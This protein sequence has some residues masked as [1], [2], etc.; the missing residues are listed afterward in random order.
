MQECLFQYVTTNYKKGVDL[1]PLIR[2]LE[3]V[4]LSSKE[5]T[6]PTGTIYRAPIETDKKI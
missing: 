2:K 5:P 4:D 6:S 1:V 3:D